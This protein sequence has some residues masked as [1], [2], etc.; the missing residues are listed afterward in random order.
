MQRFDLDLTHAHAFPVF[1]RARPVAQFGARAGQQF[2]RPPGF[3][4]GD[5]GQILVVL[6]GV[7]RVGDT[8]ALLACKVVIVVHVPAHVEY[9]CF[10]GVFGTE[11]IGRVS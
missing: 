10:P 8:Q 11:E 7:R 5:T 2:Q 4:L 6:V 9:Q 3:E 1:Q